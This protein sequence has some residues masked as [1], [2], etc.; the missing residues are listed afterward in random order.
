MTVRKP[1]FTI[2]E[3]QNFPRKL[4]ER[5]EQQARGEGLSP[6]AVLH[7]LIESYVTRPRHDAAPKEDTRS[8]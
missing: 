4:W 3:S 2:R 6:L 1:L 7:R 5:F 8:Q